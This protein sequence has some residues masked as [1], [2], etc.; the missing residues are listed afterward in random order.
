MKEAFYFS[1]FRCATMKKHKTNKDSVEREYLILIEF[2]FFNFRLS[3]FAVRGR[4]V[5]SSLLYVERRDEFS[6]ETDI[7]L[8][9]NVKQKSQFLGWSLEN[10]YHNCRLF[11]SSII[12]LFIEKLSTF[13]FPSIFIYLFNLKFSSDFENILEILDKDFFR[14][15]IAS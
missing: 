11:T 15:R 1:S 4:N 12:L 9:K 13:K 14:N 6:S 8:G 3:S 10:T 2:L 5:L 7:K